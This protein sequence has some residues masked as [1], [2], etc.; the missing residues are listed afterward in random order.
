M[1]SLMHE[2]THTEKPTHRGEWLVNQQNNYR[3]GGLLLVIHLHIGGQQ[4]AN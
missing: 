1:K 4:I 3:C 2:C